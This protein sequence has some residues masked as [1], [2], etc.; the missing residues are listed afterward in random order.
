MAK[1][2]KIV[3]VLF[4]ASL[5]LFAK[6]GGRDSEAIK[7]PTEEQEIPNYQTV[8]IFI[9]SSGSMAGYF[10]G[11]SQIKDILKQYYD[12]ISEDKNISD[13]VS[14]NFINQSIESYQNDINSYLSVSASKCTALYTKLDEILS[15]VMASVNDSTTNI[16]ISDYCFT[17]DNGSF[18]RAESGITKIFTESIARNKNLSVSIFKY[19]SDFKGKFFPGGIKCNQPRPF[20]IWIF[21]NKKQMKKLTRML[22]FQSQTDVPFLIRTNSARMFDK[23]GAIIVKEWDKDRNSVRG[24]VSY[25]LLV[26]ADMSNIVLPN[27]ELLN[28]DNYSLTEGY[29][30]FSISN[31][32]GSIFEY[33][34]STSKPSPGKICLSY[35]IPELPEW[36]IESNYEGSGI[37]SDGKTLGVKYLIEG[38][39]D[40]FNN[41]KDNMYFTIDINL[42]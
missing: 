6:C 28:K 7:E 20:Y 25:S 39:Y 36:V 30:I 24:D 29:D 42:K 22:S 1:Y 17:S 4:L 31:K 34:I 11:N 32:S 35:E 9:E 14:L 8:N 13:T 12:R 40:A 2:L 26:E 27:D 10:S 18:Q 38:V 33:V 19:L 41:K 21:G 16:L 23:D 37:P 5:F 3:I 15:K